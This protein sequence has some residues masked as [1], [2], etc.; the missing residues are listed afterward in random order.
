MDTIA[1]VK[2]NYDG[3]KRVSLLP[4]DIHRIC[5]KLAYDCILIES[6]FG[7]HLDIPDS[8][9]R[10]VGCAISDRAQCFAAK[11]VFSLKL[12]QPTDY[13]MLQLGTKLIGWMHPNGSGQLFATTIAR[14]KLITMFDI[15]SVYPRIYKPDG[16]IVDV[17]GLPPHFLWENSYIA[18]RAATMLGLEQLE[19]KRETIKKVCVLGAG[20]VSQGAFQYLSTLGFKPRMF[21]RRTLNIFYS[22]VEDY[23]VIVNGIEMDIEGAHILSSEHLERTRADVLIIDA[24]ADAGRAIQGTE[25]QTLSSP[26]GLICN[27]KYTL[28]NNAPTLLYQEASKVISNVV[29]QHLLTRRFF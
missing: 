25:Y 15:D 14:E 21:H 12:I 9:Y 11:Y 3:E 26:V 22:E 19:K 20:S 8:E 16:Q 2:P 27:R 17:T 23:E 6:G 24:A 18:G 1:F 29:A 28:V 5:N 4:Q 10:N 13:D 7:A